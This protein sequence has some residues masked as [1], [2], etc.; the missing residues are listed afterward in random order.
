MEG[1]QVSFFEDEIAVRKHW[2]CFLCLGILMIILGLAALS[3]SAFVTVFS[4]FFLG[5]ALVIS[6]VLQMLHGFWAHS[7]NGVFLS[8]LMGLIYVGVG[9]ACSVAP[10]VSA[11]TITAVM[12]SFCVVA[13]IY[14]IVGALFN[15]FRYCGWVFFN[16]LI[17]LLLGLLIFSGWPVSGLWVIGAYIGVD[18]MLLGWSW[19]ILA[20]SIRP[21]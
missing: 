17:T 5:L 6:G 12:A 13:G 19:T 10:V 16:G 20:L 15:R 18:L 4:V 1:K 9:I 7:W 14:R 2:K 21:S 3:A 8:I 11:M